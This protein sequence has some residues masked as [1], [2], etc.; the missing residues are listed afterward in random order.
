MLFETGGGVP[1]NAY[2]TDAEKTV[3]VCFCCEINTRRVEFCVLEVVQMTAFDF[4]RQS[5]GV[6][7]GISTRVQH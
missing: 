6:S 3:L 5:G 7:V 1:L 4:F 2:Q